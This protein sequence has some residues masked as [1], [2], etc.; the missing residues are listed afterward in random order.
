MKCELPEEIS[1]SSLNFYFRKKLFKLTGNSYN[2]ETIQ[3]LNI[4]DTCK[5]K[6]KCNKSNKLGCKSKI[7]ISFDKKNKIANIYQ[8]D[9]IHTH[10]VN[11]KL[12]RIQFKKKGTKV[13]LFE[14]FCLIIN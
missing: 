14:T 7:I 3:N 5:I 6:Y 10:E 13:I 12:N 1:K 4:F 2:L 8:N 9:E 11:I